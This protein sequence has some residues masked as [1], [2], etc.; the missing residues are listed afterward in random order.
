MKIASARATSGVRHSAAPPGAVEALPG[1]PEDA[2]SAQVAPVMRRSHTVIGSDDGPAEIPSL[3][4][5][6]GSAV[7]AAASAAAAKKAKLSRRQSQALDKRML[8]IGTPT[9]FVHKSHMTH[10][11]AVRAVDQKA[12]EPEIPTLGADGGNDRRGG[13]GGGGG[14]K[15]KMFRRQSQALDKR[16]IKIGTPTNFRHTE[17]VSATDIP[18]LAGRGAPPA[19][20][21]WGGE[22]RPSSG[23][24]D[25]AAGADRE[26]ETPTREVTAPPSA[27]PSA[28]RAIIGGGPTDTGELFGEE[29]K[30]MDRKLRDHMEK[31]E[32]AGGPGQQNA[33]DFE[34]RM[35]QTEAQAKAADAKLLTGPTDPSMTT[36]FALVHNAP[37]AKAAAAAAAPANARYSPSKGESRAVQQPALSPPNDER[38]GAQNNMF[39]VRKLTITPAKSPPAPAAADEPVAVTVNPSDDAGPAESE[40][41]STGGA[42]ASAANALDPGRAVKAAVRDSSHDSSPLPEEPDE[43]STQAAKLLDMGALA[44]QKLAE[45]EAFLSES[46]LVQGV[47]P[48]DKD[49]GRPLVRMMVC[50]KNY[51][52]EE[53]SVYENT[54]DE[55]TMVSGIPVKVFGELGEDGYFVGEISGK[56]G[57][58]PADYLAE[59]RQLRHHF[60]PF[61]KFIFTRF[62]APYHPRA[63]CGVYFTWC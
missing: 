14:K 61:F 4:L 58:V 21:A 13:G 25:A 23:E 36:E 3:G 53:M 5:G 40:A 17:H 57:L 50:C 8:T 49:K 35:L 55:L 34:S 9:N 24:P 30:D 26:P 22:A 2:M 48:A 38:C 44:A 20:A 46:H 18:P 32:S 16:V 31:L 51:Y 1:A 19:A 45:A 37:G 27:V 7:P 59:V 10:N 15:N 47:K 42:I 56:R 52:P 41:P 54:E 6:D 63:R 11:E 28:V 43:W 39:A 62:S 60:G 33:I 12:P 29:L